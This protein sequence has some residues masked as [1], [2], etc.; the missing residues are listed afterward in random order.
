MLLMLMTNEIFPCFSIFSSM[1]HM[2]GTI[3]SSYKLCSWHYVV[4]WLCLVTGHSEWCSCTLRRR[5]GSI[6]K[7]AF[8]GGLMIDRLG[9]IAILMTVLMAMT[10]LKYFAGPMFMLNWYVERDGVVGKSLDEN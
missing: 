6:M 10:T 8:T 5:K 3:E 9:D 1:S 4:G 2:E 7:I